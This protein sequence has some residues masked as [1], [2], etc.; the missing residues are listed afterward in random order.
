MAQW[1]L[2]SCQ[3]PNQKKHKQHDKLCCGQ[4]NDKQVH[5]VK[6]WILVNCKSKYLVKTA[7]QI[8]GEELGSIV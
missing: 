3:T 1:L 5:V 8:K 7:D 2:L 4:R 6:L